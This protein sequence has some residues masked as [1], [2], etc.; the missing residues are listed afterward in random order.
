[1]IVKCGVMST[2]SWPLYHAVPSVVSPLSQRG[3]PENFICNF[4]RRET[5]MRFGRHK[6][7]RYFS[8]GCGGCRPERVPAVM[9]AMASLGSVTC[10]VPL[11]WGLWTTVF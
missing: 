3:K 9:V 8:S 4:V 11:V 1:M 10:C 6:G 2:V 5:G 7:G